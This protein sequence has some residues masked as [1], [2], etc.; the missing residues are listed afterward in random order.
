MSQQPSYPTARRIAA[1]GTFDGVHLGHRAV[2]DY[3]VEEG[4]R[5]GLVPAVVT[6]SS[7]PLAVVR[8]ERVPLALCTLE[9]RILRLNEAGVHDVIVLPFDEK[10]RRMTARDF[11]AF[12][13]AGYG[14]EA[15]VLGF[16]NSFGS[17]RLKEFDGY[18]DAAST[19]GVEILQAPRY[20]YSGFGEASSTAIRHLIASGDVAMASRLLGHAVSLSGQ[21]I[22]GRRI[23]RTIGFPT[24]NLQIDPSC[25]IPAEGVYA[26]RACVVGTDKD[27]AG[28]VP[29]FATA[30]SAVAAP[31]AVIDATADVGADG[32]KVVS[33]VDA[34]ADGSTVS[35]A[36]GVADADVPPVSSVPHVP[37][38]PDEGADSSPS[39][40]RVLSDLPCYPAMVNIGRRPTVDSSAKPQLTVEAHL[41]GFE[42]NLYGSRLDVEF[43]HRLRS[44]QKFDS[45]ASLISQLEA[46]KV[47]TLRCLSAPSITN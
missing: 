37:P 39:G 3:L 25:A 7:H 4:T 30:T 27:S 42:G 12:L 14:V 44:E 16:N 21:V 33:V 40:F 47:A 32:V 38:V 31:D 41:I 17:D 15:I 1:I 20:E 8:P 10:L 2:V 26:C 29:S 6:F 34:T 13:H 9:Q 43:L 11:I 22:G 36:A 28:F 18:V 35:A 24:A 19:I 46:D 45:L 23:G 5:R